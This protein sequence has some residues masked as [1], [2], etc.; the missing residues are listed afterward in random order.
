MFYDTAT[1]EGKPSGQ[2]LSW[3]SGCFRY[4]M[5]EVQ[6]QSLAKN[7]NYHIYY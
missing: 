3:R 1:C 7:F 2:W 5:S 4:Q 6:I